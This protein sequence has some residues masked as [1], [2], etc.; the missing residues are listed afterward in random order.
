MAGSSVHRD[1]AKAAVERVAGAPVNIN[2][3]HE[4]SLTAMERFAL[5]VTLHVGTMGVFFGLVVWNVVWMLWN[6]FAPPGWRFDNYPFPLL[7]FCS[8]FLQLIWLP[9]LSVGQTIL[10]RHQEIRAEADYAH[11]TETHRMIQELHQAALLRP[12]GVTI[13]IVE[14][15]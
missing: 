9:L 2:E 5:Y 8:N 11:N 6:W 10:S 14:L 3:L 1:N 12:E 4:A 7:L 13:N 15:P